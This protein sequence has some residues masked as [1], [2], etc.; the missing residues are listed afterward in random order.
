MKKLASTHAKNNSKLCVQLPSNILNHFF[1]SLSLCCL[2]LLRI[3]FYTTNST[4]DSR[5]FVQPT[6]Q[7]LNAFCFSPFGRFCGNWTKRHRR[8]TEANR[9]KKIKIKPVIK[10]MILTVCLQGDR[11]WWH[12][13]RQQQQLAS[14]T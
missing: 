10:T 14:S 1:P 11:W 5:L 7:H 13:A 8:C 4:R 12:K 6:Y 3:S 9:K 2:L